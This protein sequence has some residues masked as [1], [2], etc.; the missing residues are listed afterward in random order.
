M[1]AG[2]DGLEA[3]EVKR[4]ASAFPQT[5]IAAAAVHIDLTRKRTGS[6]PLA[7]GGTDKAP[8]PVELFVVSLAT[9]VAYFARQYLEPHAGLA[10][11][12]EYRKTDRPAGSHRLDQSAGGR[13]RGLAGRTGK[14]HCMWSCPTAP[15]TTPVGT[16]N[17]RDQDR[18]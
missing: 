1:I 10:L 9:C 17:R 15:S 3:K 2:P 14:G 16:A 12:A 11:H 7:G 13:A 18:Q 6:G 5:A 8:S 4:E